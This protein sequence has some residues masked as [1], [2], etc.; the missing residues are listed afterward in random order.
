MPAGPPPGTVEFGALGST[1]RENII[2]DQGAAQ[3]DIVVARANRSLARTES[4]CIRNIIIFH[5]NLI[6]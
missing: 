4:I 2:S 5:L 1:K 3:G 6:I